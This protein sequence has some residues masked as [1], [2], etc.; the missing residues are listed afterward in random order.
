MGV[1]PGLNVSGYGVIRADSGR[2]ELIEAGIVRSRARRSIEERIAEIHEGMAEVVQQHQPA[3]L[4]LE[5]LFSHY[6]RPKTAILMG[7]ARGVI[8]LAAAQ[9][10]IPVRSYEPTKVKKVMT[11]NGHAPKHQMQQAV[12]LQLGLHEVP[13]PAD[14]ADALAI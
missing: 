6:S 14:V 2:C 13:E 11:G 4:A 7:H 8:C 12:K 5:Q 3:Y 1:D 9:S 10:G